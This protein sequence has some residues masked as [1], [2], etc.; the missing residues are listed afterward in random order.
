M[1]VTST[2]DD[3]HR[4]A[5][6]AADSPWADRLARLGFAARGVVYM[7]IGA[8]ALEVARRGANGQQADKEGA[9]REIAERPWGGVLLVVLAIGLGGYALWRATEALWGHRDESDDAKRTAKRLGSAAR[10]VFY[11]VFC[12]TTVRFITGGAKEGGSS[13]DQEQTWVARALD[14][15]LGQ[16]LVA[17]AGLAVIAGAAYIGFRGLSQKFEER[18]DTSEMGPVMGSTVDVLGTVGMVARSLVFAL[19]G[20]L[21]V[22]AAL[23][24]DAQEAQGLDGTLKTMASQPFGQILLAVTAVGL[25][26]YGLYSWAEARYRQL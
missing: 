19:A 16:W 3:V 25:F 6:R 8:I 18:L 5:R 22:R 1:T 21:L 11:A 9:L 14:L 12:A 24:Y 2:V 26:A 7:I 10:A 20:Y 15:P 4:T 23:D 17:G 13:G